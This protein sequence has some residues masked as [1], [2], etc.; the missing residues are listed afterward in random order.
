MSWQSLRFE[1]ERLILVF[2]GC[3]QKSTRSNKK[4]FTT[5]NFART[6]Q[7]QN[8]TN[9]KRELGRNKVKFYT[10]IWRLKFL[11]NI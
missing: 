7:T 5:V 1:S 2:H 9:D 10:E 11:V 8:S 4:P 6:V 3:D